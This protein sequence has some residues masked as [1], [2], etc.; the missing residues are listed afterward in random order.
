VKKLDWKYIL[1]DIVITMVVF[2]VVAPLAW[3]IANNYAKR[4]SVSTSKKS[5][6]NKQVVIPKSTQDGSPK[7]ASENS[8]SVQAGD[9]KNQ[10]TIA[11]NPSV[12]TGEQEWRE[13]KNNQYSFQIGYPS[14]YS[15]NELANKNGVI[16]SKYK[17]K[18]SVN[19]YNGGGQDLQTF[20]SNNYPNATSEKSF[21]N[22]ETNGKEFW[23]AGNKYVVFQNKRGDYVVISS[24]NPDKITAT[25]IE[26]I[27]FTFVPL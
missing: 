7:K 16:L 17:S 1:A 21:S 23:N 20:I 24:S 12:T 8:A 13:Y 25:E 4:P 3:Y 5:V 14:N 22:D 10:A 27:A 11:E 26:D 9:S 19:G 15:L 6:V 18:I 2:A